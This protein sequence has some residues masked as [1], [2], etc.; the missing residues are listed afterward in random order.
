M[1]IEGREREREREC[2]RAYA[3]DSVMYDWGTC[4]CVC[5]CECVCVRYACAH[6]E[7][8][9]A[10]ERAGLLLR[11]LLQRCVHVVLVRH[12]HREVD[13]EHLQ[14]KRYVMLRSHWMSQ[15]GNQQ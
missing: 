11:Q 3:C 4:V 14:Q 13:Q 9:V 5:V 2:V 12:V 1:K 7:L 10:V 6:R 15:D 8:A